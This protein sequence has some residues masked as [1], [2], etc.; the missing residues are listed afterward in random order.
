MKKILSLTILL[1]VT[2]I[3]SS[4]V[5][6]QLAFDDI[7]TSPWEA[8]WAF[9][10]VNTSLSLEDILNDTSGFIHEDENGLLSLVYESDSL[11][12]I[13]AASL[14]AV[15][16]QDT[17]VNDEFEMPDLPPGHTLPP[18]PVNFSFPFETEK[19]NQRIDSI[20]FSSGIYHL[21]VNTDLN[22]DEAWV[23]VVVPSLV[24][25]SNHEVLSFDIDLANG[26]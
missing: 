8:K 4:C 20:Y 1:D 24:S 15:P 11:V 12:S 14:I 26:G 10:L 6:D 23:E 9:P 7:R 25:V 16:D 19:P 5:K 22:R 2:L 18:I 17:I 21:E 13:N 3:I